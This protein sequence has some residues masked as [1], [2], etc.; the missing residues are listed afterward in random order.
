MDHVSPFG[1]LVHLDLDA[2]RGKDQVARDHDRV[3]RVSGIGPAPESDSVVSGD[4][5]EQVGDGG[6]G[7]PAV[8]ADLV[9]SDA[10]LLDEGGGAVGEAAGG[11]T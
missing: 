10:V 7:G 1:V 11:G 8:W 2:R 9:A 4:L 3:C 5:L 6:D